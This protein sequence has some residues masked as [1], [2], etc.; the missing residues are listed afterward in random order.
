M[1]EYQSGERSIARNYPISTAARELTK[2]AGD[3]PDPEPPKTQ[4]VTARIN[5]ANSRLE[6]L[7]STLGEARSM[8]LQFHERMRGTFPEKDPP[9]VNR[10]A[11]TPC[12]PPAV[13]DSLE[14][15]VD[16]C[17]ETTEEICSLISKI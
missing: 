7:A 2:R 8:L 11:I 3:I 9:E 13:L 1:A 5:A 12:A 10:A 4:L 17:T 16:R 14:L 6:R 15:V